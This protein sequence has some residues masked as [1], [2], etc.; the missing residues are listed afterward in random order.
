MFGPVSGGHLNPVVS[1][2]D[3]GFGGLS[4]R[5]AAAYLP[6]QVTGCIGGAVVANLMFSRAAVSISTKDRTSGAHFL[7]EV[8]ATLGLILV[9][10]ALARSGRSRMAPAAVGAYI[11]AAYFFTSSTSFANPA[12]TVGR[13]FSNT[14]A[15]IAPSSVPSFVVAQVLGGAVAMLVIKVLYPGVSPAEAADVI[16]PHHLTG[17]PAEGTAGLAA[18]VAI[19]G[20]LA[21]APVTRRANG[22]AVH[23]IAIGG[24]DAGISAALRVRELDPDAEV[25]VVVADAYPNFSICGIPYYISGEVTHWR[26]LAHRTIAD[27]EA[28]GMGLRLDTTA[29]RIDVAGRKLARHEQRR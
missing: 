2:V 4:W 3:A 28:T 13:M 1:F 16:V 22:R 18:Q 11:G 27:L 20:T 10:F 6:A 19:E 14:F 5:D 9:I 8:V 17:A 26:N 29:R 15:G 23:I 7:S 24:S 12:I 25:T 21:T